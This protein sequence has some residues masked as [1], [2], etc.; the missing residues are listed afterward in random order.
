[1]RFSKGFIIAISIVVVVSLLAI[2]ALIPLK[3]NIHWYIYSKLLRLEHKFRPLPSEINDIVLVTIDNHTLN[4][5]AERWPY[6][7]SCFAAVIDNLKKAGAKA[8]GFD[9]IFYG[10][11][12]EDEKHFSGMRSARIKTLC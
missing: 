2:G 10:D 1:M 12:T 5:M 3:N 8:I 4:S 11:S 7:R 6:P 9:F